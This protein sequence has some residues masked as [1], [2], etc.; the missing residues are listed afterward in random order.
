[1]RV[2]IGVELAEGAG[3]YEDATATEELSS[4]L[5]DDEC[6]RMI[7]TAQAACAQMRICWPRATIPP[8]SRRDG[9]EVLLAPAPQLAQLADAE[10]RDRLIAMGGLV[11][12]ITRLTR[13]WAA[14]PLDRTVP[15]HVS[16]V[17]V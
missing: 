12:P 10:L 6:G 13:W 17:A 15:L 5:C 1:M 3:V 7:A 2:S 4:S 16:S 14:S 11:R 8:C 9:G